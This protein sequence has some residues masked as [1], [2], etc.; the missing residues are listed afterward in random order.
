MLKVSSRWFISIPASPSH[1]HAHTN[2]T[3]SLSEKE[4]SQVHLLSEICDTDKCDRSSSSSRK[5]PLTNRDVVLHRSNVG[6]WEEHRLLQSSLR[7]VRGFKVTL[8][9]R[10]AFFSLTERSWQ[11]SRWQ[12]PQRLK[13]GTGHLFVAKLLWNLFF[14]VLFMILFIVDSTASESAAALECFSVGLLLVCV[15]ARW[16]LHLWQTWCTWGRKRADRK[17]GQGKVLFTVSKDVHN[18][19]KTTDHIA[20]IF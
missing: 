10:A 18:E 8:K 5:T 14:R 2:D 9:E 12:T 15:V 7:H 1:T 16:V 17:R 19:V 11:P 4:A 3:W 6:A 20:A 13:S